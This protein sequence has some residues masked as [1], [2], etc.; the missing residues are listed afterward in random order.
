MSVLRELRLFIEFRVH[1]IYFVVQQK[2]SLVHGNPVFLNF[3]SFLSN[4][5]SRRVVYSFGTT[6]QNEKTT[7]S[8]K[9]FFSATKKYLGNNI[10]FGTTTLIFWFGASLK[11]SQN[12]FITAS[13]RVTS[14]F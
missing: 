9:I 10:L 13:L 14:Y 5:L 8:A 3:V 12:H 1:Q 6:E 4:V 11:M 7:V 2:K